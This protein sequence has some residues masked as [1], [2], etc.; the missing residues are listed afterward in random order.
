MQAP[1][2]KMESVPNGLVRRLSKITGTLL[3][4]AVLVFLPKCPLCLAAWLT[5]ATGFSLS[6]TAASWVRPIISILWATGLLAI[7]LRRAMNVRQ[8]G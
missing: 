6:A 4:G 7:F 5:L 8:H 2:C 3:P 1:C